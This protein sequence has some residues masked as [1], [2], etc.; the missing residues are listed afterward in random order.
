MDISCLE[1]GSL[2]SHRHEPFSNQKCGHEPDTNPDLSAFAGR[3]VSLGIHK[4]AQRIA[5]DFEPWLKEVQRSNDSREKWR[6]RDKERK[7]AMLTVD[8]RKDRKANES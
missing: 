4:A 3:A 6:K 8:E 5:N 2:T 1:S 7:R